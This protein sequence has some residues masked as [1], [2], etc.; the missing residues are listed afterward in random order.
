MLFQ[1]NCNDMFVSN[2]L[3]LAWLAVFMLW[4]QLS[5]TPFHQT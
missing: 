3:L 4:L 2:T 5:E 1:A